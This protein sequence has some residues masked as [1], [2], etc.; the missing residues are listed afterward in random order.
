MSLNQIFQAIG[1]W[2]RWLFSGIWNYPIAWGTVWEHLVAIVSVSIAFLTFFWL[3]SL[4]FRG[5]GGLLSRLF[6][7]PSRPQ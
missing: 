5:V 6:S 7:R 3:V 4:L 1:D 2:F